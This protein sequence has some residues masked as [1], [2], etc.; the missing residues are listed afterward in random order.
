[1]ERFNC[2]DLQEKMV[3]EFGTVPELEG[4]PE[5][6]AHLLV[7]L[8]KLTPQQLAKQEKRATIDSYLNL[9]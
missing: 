4:G 2:Y 6:F 9:M 7:I 1:M 5:G 8:G 3:E